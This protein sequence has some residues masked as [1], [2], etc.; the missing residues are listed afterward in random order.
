MMFYNGSLKD[1]PHGQMAY[2]VERRGPVA[3][4]FNFSPVGNIVYGYV[5]QTRG[6]PYRLGRIDSAARNADYLDGVL[7]VSWPHGPA[8]LVGGIDR[9]L[10][11]EDEVLDE[12][13]AARSSS[14][15]ALGEPAM[16]RLAALV[17]AA[18]R[19]GVGVGIA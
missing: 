4:R 11:T 5:T 14:D 8:R 17:A 7:L 18:E 1:T 9:S 16:V 6:T 3:E 10:D 2:V 12:H 13:R 19:A 15:L